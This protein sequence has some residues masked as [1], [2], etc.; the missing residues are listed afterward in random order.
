MTPDFTSIWVYLST[1]PLLWLTATLLAY[2]FAL[3]LHARAK[4]SPLVNPVMI[5]VVILVTLLAL[6]NTPYRN[7]FEG[8]QFVHFLLGPATVALAIPLYQQ[9][10][11]LRRHWFAFL[12]GTLVGST[13]AVA[14]AMGIA[15]LLGASPAV[16]LSLAPKSVTTPIAMGIAEKIGGLPSLTAVMVIVT[17]IVGAS[18]AQFFMRI[19]KIRDDSICGFAMGVTAHGLGTARAFQVSAEMGAFAGL[20]MGMTGV[21]TAVLLPLALKLFGVI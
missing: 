15:W 10:A 3:G 17:G 4:A 19:I 18:L 2:Q 12:A 20:A 7:Y 11:K 5:A 1:S 14:A 13:A 9:L 16:V 21:L 6:T 8:A